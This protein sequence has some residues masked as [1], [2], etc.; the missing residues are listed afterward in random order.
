MYVV[1]IISVSMVSINYINDAKWRAE[2]L[3]VLVVINIIRLS[4]CIKR[5]F[6]SIGK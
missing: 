5:N 4:T 6:V 3:S 2:F 1:V